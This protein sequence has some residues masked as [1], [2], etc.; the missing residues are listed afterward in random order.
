MLF[1]SLHILV[2]NLR[3]RDDADMRNVSANDDASLLIEL[4]NRVKD[5]IDTGVIQPCDVHLAESLISL[6][7]HL[8]RLSAMSPKSMHQS[9][10]DILQP[11]SATNIYDTL[12]CQVSELQSHRDVHMLLNSD[13]SISQP[14]I[15]VVE[16][17]ILWQKIDNDLNEVFRLCRECTDTI[18]QLTS[19]NAPY[20]NLPALG[21][22]S[23]KLIISPS[24]QS[25]QWHIKL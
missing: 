20:C 21:R 8:N 10:I 9:P 16:H 6:L 25:Y 5:L 15:L 17:G 24:F 2:S 3:H 13:Q 19:P 4:T 22:D 23:A 7:T 11:P 18:P 14:P 1:R 12:R